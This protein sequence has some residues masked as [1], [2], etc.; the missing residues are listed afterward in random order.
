MAAIGPLLLG[1]VLVILVVFFSQKMT[2]G[3]VLFVFNVCIDFV[4]SYLATL[5]PCANGC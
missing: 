5:A 2:V 3:A 1:I 4:T